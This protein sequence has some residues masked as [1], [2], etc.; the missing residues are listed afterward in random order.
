MLEREVDTLMD[1]VNLV[2]PSQRLAVLSALVTLS[3]FS[4]SQ[5]GAAAD[6][7]GSLATPLPKERA[8]PNSSTSP[9]QPKVVARTA[10]AAAPP[11]ASGT[12][13]VEDVPPA[14]RDLLFSD[15][16][17]RYCL[18]QSI[19]LDASRSLLNRARR[20]QVDYF[21]NLVADFNAR[22]GHYRYEVGA[23]ESA[24][25][26]VEAHRAQIDRDARNAYNKQFGATAQGGE[27]ESSAKARDLA[28]EREA[29]PR[30]QQSRAAGS[31]ESVTPTTAAP[32]ASPSNR[33]PA[34][35]PS[36]PP[37]SAARKP[38][39]QSA[40]SSRRPDAPPPGSATQPLP[41]EV[42]RATTAGTPPAPSKEPA[43]PATP[44]PET[45]QPTHPPSTSS[46]ESGSAASKSSV[47]PWPTPAAKGPLPPETEAATSKPSPKP[48]PVAEAAA[49]P[50]A[51]VAS[52][53]AAT[54]PPA[55]SDKP[56]AAA[57][58]KKRD[59]AAAAKTTPKDS[60]PPQTTA[61]A[62]GSQQ[63]PSAADGGPH[64]S[65]IE[66]P[67][68]LEIAPDKRAATVAA[69]PPSAQPS[70]AA[71]AP[72][73]ASKAATAATPKPASDEPPLEQF[74]REI[75]A[76]GARVISERDYPAQARGK[77][78]EG[79]VQIEVRFAA[80][81]YIRSIGVGESS[82]HAPLDQFAMEM[83]REAQ[84]PPVPQ[85]LQSQDFSVRFPIVFRKS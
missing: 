72:S 3:C 61:A 46:V 14:G 1:R 47:Q 38:Q 67:S 77:G 35:H 7:P 74:S 17:I 69:A 78:W 22:C 59:P 71:A 9:G 31:D 39:A 16:Q 76:A 5:P 34:A 68:T 49:P 24:R 25:A 66:A 70:T 26:D 21:N 51:P 73:S 4:V 23:L 81:G 43:A 13:L 65:A 62:R 84:F 6:P 60:A 58:S 29:V 52:Q 83:A 30:A 36:P 45:N 15:A 11:A 44:L 75:Q 12:P 18:A 53:P 20:E 28:A 19:R 85:A 57:N 64:A 41:L 50:P 32:V 80:G 10:P 27:A 54:A 56:R 40:D 55:T 82:G 79:T 48:A 2:R 42:G 63:G 33:E 8:A 37:A